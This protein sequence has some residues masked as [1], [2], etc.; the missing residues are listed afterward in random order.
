MDSEIANIDQYI[1]GCPMELH[2][3][4]IQIRKTIQDAAPEATEAIKYGMPTFI[5][6]G[7][8]VHFAACK[9]HIGLYPNPSALIAF[10]NEIS[11][12]KSS[13]GVVRF[14]FHQPIP[15]HLITRMVEFRVKEN[16]SKALLRKTKK[17]K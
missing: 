4:L 2:P 6:H 7:N 5:F 15:F 11:G 9:N 12:Y 8:L 3:V 1:A 14:P 10:S 13:K 16:L 17:G